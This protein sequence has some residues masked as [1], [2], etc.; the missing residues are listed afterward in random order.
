MEI[1]INSKT[2]YYLFITCIIHTQLD[3]GY[4]LLHPMLILRITDDDL[5]INS[6]LHIIKTCF[7]NPDDVL[8]LNK[9]KEVSFDCILY[10]D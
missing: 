1:Q 4:I 9:V 8:R 10:F 5:R 3:S 6:K 2:F 7:F